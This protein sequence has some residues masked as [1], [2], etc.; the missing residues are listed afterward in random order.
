MASLTEDRGGRGED[1]GIPRWGGERREEGVDAGRLE[2]R[3]RPEGQGLRTWGD[4][5]HPGTR[6]P[7][8]GT[9]WQL[10]EAWSPGRERRW[11]QG[12]EP[13]GRDSG[14]RL[15][16]IQGP[17]EEIVFRGWLGLGGSHCDERP[18]WGWGL[19]WTLRR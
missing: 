8:A 6:D 14:G 10:G 19:I 4:W 7:S 13:A 17:G 12:G 16:G 18:G 5:A 9:T 1:T 3:G 2:G 15:L 11:V